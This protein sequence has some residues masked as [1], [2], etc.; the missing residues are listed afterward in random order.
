MPKLYSITLTALRAD[1]LHEL[2][3]EDC[4]SIHQ[5]ATY[6]LERAIAQAMQER[7]QARERELEAYLEVANGPTES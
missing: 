6:M 1:Q 4:R 3:M 7:D 5:Q 2:A